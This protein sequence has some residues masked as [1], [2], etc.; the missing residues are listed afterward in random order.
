MICR[1]HLQSGHEETELLVCLASFHW[2][3]PF[4]KET[5]TPL[6][7]EHSNQGSQLLNW[8]EPNRV[9]IQAHVLWCLK[10]LRP[11]G[12]HPTQLGFPPLLGPF[13]HKDVR[14]LPEAMQ[15]QQ[16]EGHTSAFDV[17]VYQTCLGTDSQGDL[18]LSERG[19][20]LTCCFESATGRAQCLGHCFCC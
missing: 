13:L 7:R 3:S 18:A 15:R 4:R 12:V 9:Y 11:P 2:T 5:K 8:P 17:A 14:I 6:V 16:A 19:F 1:Q 20:P 10:N